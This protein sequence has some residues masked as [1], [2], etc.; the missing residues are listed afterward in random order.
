MGWTHG[1]QYKRFVERS[2]Q[3]SPRF[4][5]GNIPSV[6]LDLLEDLGSYR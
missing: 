4:V 5:A 1:E 3:V 2:E 6:A